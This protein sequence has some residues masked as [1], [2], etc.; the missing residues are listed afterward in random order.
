MSLAPLLH[1]L[2]PLMLVV[3]RMAG[4]LLF[5][6]V[7]SNRTL[8]R[9]FRA[10]L[11]FTLG[12]AVYAG[13]P[14]DVR[15]PPRADV[16]ELLPLILSETLI[17][18]V[19]GFLMG[20]PVL[21]LDMAGFLMGHQM[22]MGLARVYNPEMGADSDMFGQVL[23]YLGLGAFLALGGLEA[24][25]LALASTF[26]HVPIGAFALNRAP[27]E[28]ITGVI[29]SGI[30]LSARVAAPVMAI[31]FLLLIAFGFLA[32]T[33][34]QINVMSVGFTLKILFGT[35]MLIAS[36]ATMQSAAADEIDRVMKLAVDWARSLT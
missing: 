22:G 5:T 6:P 8:P 32:K 28:L 10:M 24:A 35:A 9:R 23:V 1:H 29:S 4:L 20:L 7:L 12:L 26:Q 21:A 13:L 2:T 33:I 25:Y 14:P 27:L 36:V 16:I 3:V 30:E 17:G 11:A 34:P 15:E 31:V 19:I 18:A